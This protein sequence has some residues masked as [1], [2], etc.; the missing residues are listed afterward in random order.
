MK[1][2]EPLV[3]ISSDDRGY[4]TERR[5]SPRGA[6]FVVLALKQDGSWA[7]LASFDDAAVAAE[8]AGLLDSALDFL[9]GAARRV[10][11]AAGS[12][13]P[14]KERLREFP[15]HSTKE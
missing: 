3:A 5:A 14:G 8:V 11:K 2:T 15:A 1:Q 7:E 13:D 10:A 6:L 12:D 4:I 9:L